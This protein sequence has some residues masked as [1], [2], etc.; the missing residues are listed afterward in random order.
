[1]TGKELAERRI[2]L[3]LGGGGAKGLAH[4]LALEA[5]DQAGVRPVA[6]AGTSIGAI[7]GGVYAAGYSAKAIRSHIVS[8]FRDRPDV[9]A[10]LFRARAG[11]FSGI[12]S[13]ALGAAVQIDGEALLR[14]FWPPSMP[15]RFSDLR[16]PFTAVATDYYGRSVAAFREGPLRP[17]VAASLAVPG[18]VK[19]VEIDKRLL[20]DGV[21]ANPLPFDLLP[22]DCDMIIAVDVVGGPESANAEVRP[23]ALEVTLGAFQI[24]QSTIVEAKLAVAGPKIRLVRPDVA[25]FASLEFFSAR[26]IL[27]SAEPIRAEILALLTPP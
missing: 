23:T 27:Q 22:L 10:R 12:F 24:M 5:F 4:V 9:M 14:E 6:I 21:M 17:A 7:I 19:P 16:L 18:L 20:I 3:A 8:T 1:M 11:S 2:G 25:R 15:D 13:G 26:R